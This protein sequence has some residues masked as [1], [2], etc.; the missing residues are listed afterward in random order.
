[1]YINCEAIKKINEHLGD[2]ISKKIFAQRLLYSLTL[3]SDYIRQMV[4]EMP[5]GTGFYD[6]LENAK[7]RSDIVIFGGG[8]WGR[9]LYKATRDYPWKCFVDSRPK[10]DSIDGMPVV[11]FSDFMKQYQGE[12]FVIAS[13][14]YYKNMYEQLIQNGVKEDKIINAG[15]LL[16]ELSKRQYFDLKEMKPAKEEFF[17]DAGSFDGMTSVYF[18]KWCM[19]N[20]D[21]IRTYVYAF[22][23]DISNAKKCHI[24][25]Q[26][27]G[28]EHEIIEK[29]CWKEEATLC[30]CANANGVSGITS[31][32]EER[33]DV[34]S[35]DKAL[36]GRKVSFIKM[37]IEGAEIQAL[38]GAE[39]IIKMNRP[40]LAIS[41]YHRPEDIWK[42]PERILE[43]CPEYQF[44]LRHYS[45]GDFETV[46]YALP[47]Q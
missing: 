24:N 28:I 41:I 21:D 29:G 43:F 44:F 25:L 10:V 2:D 36:E 47:Q 14:I 17:V 22:E 3:D 45:L 18:K 13:R 12:V 26:E 40:K 27:C 37:D 15:Y 39:E 20:G 7:K 9:D 34:T 1:M 11:L 35:M 23:P 33:V 32:G 30:F 19:E 31:M 4:L 38:D 42:I 6:L 8:V 46:L 5:E 16:D